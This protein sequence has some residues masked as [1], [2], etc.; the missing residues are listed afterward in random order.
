M[1]LHELAI[2]QA[3]L[4]KLAM[5]R[6]DDEIA[7]CGRPQTALQVALDAGGIKESIS[8]GNVICGAS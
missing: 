5:P 6:D 8:L 7:T 1:L 3:M 2:F 4:H